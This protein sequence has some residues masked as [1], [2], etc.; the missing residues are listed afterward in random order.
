MNSIRKGMSSVKSSLEVLNKIPVWMYAVIVLLYCAF[1]WGKLC[2]NRNSP[3]KESF[4]DAAPTLSPK[5]AEKEANL[6]KQLELMEKIKQLEKKRMEDFQKA[7][8]QST[9]K[10]EI[11]V[12]LKSQIADLQSKLK[13]CSQQARAQKSEDKRDEASTSSDALSLGSSTDSEVPKKSEKTTIEAMNTVVGCN[14]DSDCNLFY[15]DGRNTCKSNKQCRCEVGS[16]VL[17]QMGPTNY[18]D[19]KDMTDK[20]RSIFKT[21]QNYDNFT[22]QDYKNWLS[23]YENDYFQLSDEHLINLRKMRRGEPLSLR[24]IPSSR[25]YPPMESQKY[26]AEMYDKLTNSEQIVA[27]INSSTTGIQ[28]GY[29]YKDYSDLSQPNALPQLRVVNGEIERKYRRPKEANKALGV[30]LEDAVGPYQKSPNI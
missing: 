21:M 7:Y 9:D 16:G 10:E 22:I 13:M 23:L 15:G 20:E 12:A 28:V 4:E 30:G 11:V 25:I 17:C 6:K 3:L 1:M 2:S 24:D 19:P 26:Y 18:K 5:E 27:P 29:N 8:S 14:T